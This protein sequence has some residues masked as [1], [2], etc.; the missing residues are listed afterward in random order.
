MDYGRYLD[1]QTELLNI[2]TKR[3]RLNESNLIGFFIKKTHPKNKNFFHVPIRY[4]IIKLSPYFC[5]CL[6]CV[7]PAEN[8]TIVYQILTFGHLFIVIDISG[9]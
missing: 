1:T 3:D 9:F 8:Y 6:I 2:P 5:K 7:C 4:T